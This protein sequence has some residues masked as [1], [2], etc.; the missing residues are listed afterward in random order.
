MNVLEPALDTGGFH[1][2]SI[3]K[4]YSFQYYNTTY[5]TDMQKIQEN[6]HTMLHIEALHTR[7]YIVVLLFWIFLK[8]SIFTYF[9]YYFCVCVCVVTGNRT[10]RGAGSMKWR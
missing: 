6:T 1:I 3:I 5:M 4:S 9:F 2:Y 7:F 10:C 8:F